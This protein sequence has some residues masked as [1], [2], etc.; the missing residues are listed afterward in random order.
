[1]TQNAQSSTTQPRT[2]QYDGLGRITSETNPESGATSTT[3]TYDT[4]STCGTYTGDLVKK[5]DQVGN[6]ICYAYDKMHRLTSVTYPSGSYASVTPSKYFVYDSATVDSVAMSNAKSRMAEAYTCFSPCSSKL[7]DL[8]FSYT[9]RG[10]IGEVYEY[11]PNSGGYDTSTATYWANG[12]LDG[13]TA[14]TGYETN[15]GVDGEGRVYS[16]ANGAALASTSYN[17]ASEPTALNL[18]WGDSDTF[19][20]DA[21]DRMNQ[22]SFNVN[23][24]SVVG[25]P[26][27]NPNGSLGSLAIT[28]P[29]NSSDAQTCNYSHDDLARILS[30][31]C[32]TIF[33]DTY[34]YDPFGISRRVGRRKISSQAIVRLPTTSRPSGPLRPLTMR[35]GMSRTM[36]STHTLG[37]RTAGLSQSTVSASPTT[38]WGVRLN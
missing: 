4:D 37:T 23:G 17:A 16:T 29:F 11:T 7:T 24:Q 33:S 20:Y 2:Y 38:P 12:V 35:T 1:M 14:S 32:G 26:T 6:V 31:S 36:G 19:G 25:K 9:A 10:Q 3:Y 13:L 22:Y 34:T 30:V 21:M 15:Y 5:V 18:A 8:G 27:W 28:D